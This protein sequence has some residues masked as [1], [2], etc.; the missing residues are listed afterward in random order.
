MA[1]AQGFQALLIEAHENKKLPQLLLPQLRQA[2]F[3]LDRM[4]NFSQK[5]KRGLRV[6]RSSIGAVKVKVG[7][8]EFGQDIDPET[9]LADSGDLEA[10]LAALFVAHAEAAAD[11]GTAIAMIIERCSIWPKPR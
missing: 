2:F 1:E 8:A 11:R 3:A 10:D 7:D 6:L 9:G 5:V 4:N